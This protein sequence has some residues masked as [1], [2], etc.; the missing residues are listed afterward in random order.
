MRQKLWFS[1]SCSRGHEQLSRC[2]IALASARS[3][4]HGSEVQEQA[5]DLIQQW[6]R[7]F[8]P[9]REALPAFAAAYERLRREG[10]RFSTVDD[11]GAGAPV[12]T[13]PASSS[14]ST[15]AD[16]SHGAAQAAA[17]TRNMGFTSSDTVMAGSGPGPAGVGVP[18]PAPTRAV[19]QQVAKLKQDLETVEEKVRLAGS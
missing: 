10:A 15:L 13:P 7:A 9:Q 5:L 1:I 8:E 18:S 14:N 19:E 17:S 11:A 4:R 16:S 6:G 2:V 12:F 3:P